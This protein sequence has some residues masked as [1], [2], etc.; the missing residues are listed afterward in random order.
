MRRLSR[1]WFLGSIIALFLCARMVASLSFASSVFP[2]IEWLLVVIPYLWYLSVLKTI[3]E[4][5]VLSRIQE[6]LIITGLSFVPLALIMRM[7]K[8]I[9]AI[10]VNIAAPRFALLLLMG[11]IANL[12]ALGI[13]SFNFKRLLAKNG[14]DRPFI[15]VLIETLVFP[16]AIWKYQ[17]RIRRWR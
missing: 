13:L 1:K 6:I 5:V 2:L 15:Q 4:N 7:L 9:S 11:I 10:G 16:V 12:I 17:D 3:K 14:I 8:D